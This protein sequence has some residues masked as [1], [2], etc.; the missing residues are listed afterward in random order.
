MKRPDIRDGIKKHFNE[1]VLVGLDIGRVIGY[2]EDEW[3]CYVIIRPRNAA[4]YWHT[5]VGGYIFL[6]FLKNQN[7]A[8]VYDDYIRLDSLLT[9]NGCKPER[10][11]IEIYKK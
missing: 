10:E 11:F 4:D 7:N 2:A 1:P 3:D 8:G 6:D 5:A 9:L